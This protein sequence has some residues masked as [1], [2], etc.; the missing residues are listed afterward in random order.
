[1]SAEIVANFTPVRDSERL[2]ILDVLRG[3]AIFG[4]LLVNMPLYNA[5]LDLMVSGIKWWPGAADRAAEWFIHFFAQGKF[6]TLF[7]F[8]FGLGFSLQMERAEAAGLPAAPLFRRRLLVLFFIGLAHA[9]LIWWGD[10]LVVYALVGFLLALFCSTGEKKLLIWSGVFLFIPVL[11][12]GGLVGLLE[13][14]RTAPD[15]GREID[16]GFAEEA[17]Q[18][19]ALIKEAIRIYSSGSFSGIMAMRARDFAVT[20]GWSVLFFVPSVLGMFLLGLYAGKRRLFQNLPENMPWVRKVIKWGLMVG[21]VANLVYVVANEFSSYA[22]PS[23]TGLLA[24]TALTFG[25]PALCFFYVS[26]LILLFQKENWKE[27]L[28]PLAAV[29]RTAASNY[30]FQSAICTMVFYSY[31]LGFYGKIGPA[32][33]LV[34]SAALFLIQVFLSQWWLKLFRFGP[35]EWLWR[36]LTYGKRQPFRIPEKAVR[37]SM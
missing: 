32:L 22:V 10:I 19:P 7:S 36:S 14:A 29:G 28:L 33:G 34:L 4:I 25:A 35:V 8:L 13:L 26:V 21:L 11:I 23:P 24:L 18:Y 16:R 9:F 20:I 27:R 15:I 30:L 3:F 1:M 6:Y 2:E 37:L 12:T 5:P 31:G 17:K